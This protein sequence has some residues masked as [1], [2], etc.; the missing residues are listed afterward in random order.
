MAIDSMRKSRM[1]FGIFALSLASTSCLR[2]KTQARVFTPPPPRAQPSIPAPASLPDAPQV[3]TQQTPP[4]IVEPTPQ[5]TGEI[6][7]APKRVARRPVTPAAPKPPVS[8][9][10][11]AVSPKL[12]QMFTPGELRENTRELDETLNRVS[13]ALAEVER[14]NLTAEQKEIAERI[15][16]FRKQAEQAR[17]QD[18]LTAVS[19]ARR[20]DLLAKDLLE[21]LP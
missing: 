5:T 11:E 13:R 12:G 18:L 21:R 9:A 6:P 7:D 19:L 14:K 16:T 20:A 8:V 15:R 17:E 10:P 3:A 4:Q 1:M 2:Q